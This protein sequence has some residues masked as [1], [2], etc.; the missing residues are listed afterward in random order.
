MSAAIWIPGP[1]Q[2]LRSHDGD[3]S[4]IVVTVGVDAA[5]VAA[6]KADT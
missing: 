1:C 5:P 6:P 3:G 2:S 4:I